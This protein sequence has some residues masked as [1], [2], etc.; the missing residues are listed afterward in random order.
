MCQCPRMCDLCL[1]LITALRYKILTERQHSTTSTKR[2]RVF[3]C[4]KINVLPPC[5]KLTTKKLSKIHTKK[6]DSVSGREPHRERTSVT[7][8]VWVHIYQ[9]YCRHCFFPIFLCPWC[10]FFC[11]SSFIPLQMNEYR[12][13]LLVDRCI[14]PS[15]S[16]LMVPTVPM[17]AICSPSLLLEAAVVCGGRQKPRYRCPR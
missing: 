10:Q 16:V 5:R 4:G 2:A 1:R 7:T 6:R 14:V 12:G 15:G 9:H 11:C 17:P 13:G 8:T 3:V